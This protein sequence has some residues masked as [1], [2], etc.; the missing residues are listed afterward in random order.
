MGCGCGKAAG[1]SNGAARRYK[2][3]M[4]DGTT[5]TYLSQRDAEN[6]PN[7]DTSKPIQVVTK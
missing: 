2:A 6:A 7:R 3:T 1:G 4:L 5:K